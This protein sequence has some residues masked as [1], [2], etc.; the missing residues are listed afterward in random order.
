[1]LRALTF[2]RQ[3]LGSPTLTPP[4]SPLLARSFPPLL[5]DCDGY[6]DR[7]V[8]IDK[9]FDRD[10]NGGAVCGTTSHFRAAQGASPGRW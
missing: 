1:M 4:P 8:R 10:Y 6:Q 9:G 2:T 3:P 5:Q 7:A